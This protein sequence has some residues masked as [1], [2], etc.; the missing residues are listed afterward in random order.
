MSD[1]NPPAPPPLVWWIIWGAIIA[2][3]FTIYGFLT[4]GMVP[5][6]AT[7]PALAVLP[8]GPLA[9]SLVIRFLVFPRLHHTRFG[10]VFFIVGLALAEAGGFLGIF[11]GGDYRTA[12]AASAIVA[13]IL[14][15]PAFL[16]PSGR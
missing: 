4:S 5:L 11:L 14:H 12:F 15:V 1:Q 7:P 10:F 13:M 8:L 2:A 6:A 3:F 9:A 16:K